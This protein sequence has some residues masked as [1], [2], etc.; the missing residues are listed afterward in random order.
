MTERKQ[1]FQHLMILFILLLEQLFCNF[2]FS[3]NSLFDDFVHGRRT[4]TQPCIESSLN[5][6][7]IIAADFGNAVNCLL[8]SYHDP[9]SAAAF[10]SDFFHNGLQVQH[11]VRIRADILTNLVNHKQQAVVFSFAFHVFF[12]FTHKLFNAQFNFFFAIE[13]ITGSGFTHA[14]CFTHCRY[15]VIFKERK[16]IP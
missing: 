1:V 4:Q 3:K 13:P 2:C 12:D 10:R 6:R 9:N 5:L 16:R 11:K 7:K 15:N 8:R 14:K